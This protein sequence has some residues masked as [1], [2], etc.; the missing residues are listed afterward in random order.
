MN[1][2]YMA[3]ILYLLYSEDSGRRRWDLLLKGCR[4]LGPC[5]ADAEPHFAQHVLSKSRTYFV[6]ERPSPF[7]SGTWVLLAI[8]FNSE[9][10]QEFGILCVGNNLML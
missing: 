5:V 10:L 1:Q 4:A 6:F 8:M 9:V 2:I 7:M 3:A